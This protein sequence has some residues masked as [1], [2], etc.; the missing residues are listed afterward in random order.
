MY[1]LKNKNGHSYVFLATINNSEIISTPWDI[2]AEIPFYESLEK[3]AP[4]TIKRYRFSAYKFGS[5]Q[6]TR[7]YIFFSSRVYAFFVV[8]LFFI[9]LI[10]IQKCLSLEG[11]VYW[12]IRPPSFYRRIESLLWPRQETLQF[13][14]FALIKIMLLHHYG[15]TMN[16]GFFPFI[17]RETLF[18]LD[19]TVIFTCKCIKIKWFLLI[20]TALDVIFKL[21]L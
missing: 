6:K 18:L 4:N 1:E 17:F 8:Y 14:L 10:E 13:V 9:C 3:Q 19:T 15:S 2:H 7:I 12:A 16:F 20:R 5:A 11:V 21:N